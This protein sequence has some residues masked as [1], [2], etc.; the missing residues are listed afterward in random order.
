MKSKRG[1][2]RLLVVIFIFVTL[3]SSMT[4]TVASAAGN[5]LTN[6]TFAD[7]LTGWN[8]GGTIGSLITTD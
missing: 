2:S 5:L 1:V 4:G 7:G 3:F 6:G 8:N